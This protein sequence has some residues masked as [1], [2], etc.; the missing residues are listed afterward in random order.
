M[1]IILWSKYSVNKAIK[2]GITVEYCTQIIY[3]PD[4]I[5]KEG[6]YKRRYIRNQKDKII[7]VICEERLNF[8]YPKTV[9][10][11]SRG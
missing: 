8:I 6:E 7:V 10:R 9:I 5:T 1:K 3:N 2:A 4:E 11:T